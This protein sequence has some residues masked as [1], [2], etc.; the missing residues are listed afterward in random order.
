[1]TF[2][3]VGHS[4][5]TLQDFIEILQ[6]HGIR[7][8]ADIRSYPVSRRMPWFQ[9]P[10]RVNFLPAN[11]APAHEPLEVTLPRAGIDYVWLRGLGGRR[12]KLLEV[13]P[14]TALRSPAFRNYADYMLTSEFE[15]AI[16]ELETIGE[17]TRACIMCA[18]AQVY[19]HCHRMLVSDYLLARGHTVLHIF[20]TGPAKPHQLSAEGKIQKGVLTYPA[21][22]SLF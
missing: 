6:A 15:Q 20:G 14:N 3:T 12:K 19:Y 1:M 22:P 16:R 9:G 8:S 11:E 5:R 17:H 4:T 2:F 13:S 10:L 18:E 7:T 21:E